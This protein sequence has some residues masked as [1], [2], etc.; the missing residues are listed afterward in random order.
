MEE[1]V[2]TVL[3]D[4]YPK[5]KIIH[6]RVSTRGIILNERNQVAILKIKVEDMF[7][8]RDH[9]ELPGGGKEKDE[10]IIETLKRE[11]EEEV[12]VTIKDIVS[13]G[14]VE[15]EYNLLQRHEYSHYFMAR[16]DKD[17]KRRLTKMEED[18]LSDLLW[19][20][21]DELIDKLKNEHVEN[22]GILIHKRE[23]FMLELVKKQLK[24]EVW[25]NLLFT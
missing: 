8:K 5:T 21:I 7:G 25:F 10:T 11:M 23:L 15:Y 9:Y 1:V 3:D 12:G 22:V 20:D 17:V 6:H 16:K 18:I 13:L 19:I 14:I 2:L 4:I 24:K